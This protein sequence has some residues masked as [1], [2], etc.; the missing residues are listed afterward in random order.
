MKTTVWQ[1]DNERLHSVEVEVFEDFRDQGPIY[2]TKQFNRSDLRTRYVYFTMDEKSSGFWAGVLYFPTE[3]AAWDWYEE[4]VDFSNVI[5]GLH[6]EMD[7]DRIKAGREKMEE[8][9]G[10][11][12]ENGDVD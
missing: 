1:F 11:E 5:Q 9:L 2:R 8:E 6:L 7:K 12:E 3:A 10:L 4:R